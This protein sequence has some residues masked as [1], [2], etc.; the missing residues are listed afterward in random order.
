M[1]ADCAPQPKVTVPQKT[2]FPRVPSW[3]RVP[4]PWLLQGSGRESQTFISP[5]LWV[6]RWR[7]PQ[8]ELGCT[9]SSWGVSPTPLQGALTA[10]PGI[11]HTHLLRHSDPSGVSL[12]TAPPGSWWAALPAENSEELVRLVGRIRSPVTASDLGPQVETH[13]PRPTSHSRFS[14]PRST[15]LLVL[16]PHLVA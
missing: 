12:G 10:H 16:V 4:M 11:H 7:S 3:P 5:N 14:L 2:L 8:E 1:R 9:Q 6:I 13:H 15:L